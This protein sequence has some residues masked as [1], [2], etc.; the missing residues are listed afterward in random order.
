MDPPCATV[1]P[2]D[3]IVVGEHTY[4][5]RPAPP[6]EAYAETFGK[7][8]MAKVDMTKGMNVTIVTTA[9]R[10]DHAQLLALGGACPTVAPRTIA[11]IV[12]AQPANAKK[13]KAAPKKKSG[14]QTHMRA[15]R[16]S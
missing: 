14:V 16:A 1:C 7:L 5:L 15:S 6:A 2:P 11:S 13:R 9:T 12:P 10:D 3:S 8:D 4:P